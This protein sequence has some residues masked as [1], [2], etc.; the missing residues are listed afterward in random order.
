MGIAVIAAIGLFALGLMGYGPLDFDRKDRIRDYCQSMNSKVN[1][2]TVLMNENRPGVLTQLLD[3]DK[4]LEHVQK[5]LPIISRT[6]G[7]V[8][9]KKAPKECQQVKQAIL[10][11]LERFEKWAG[12]DIPRARDLMKNDRAAAKALLET[13]EKQLRTAEEGIRNEITVLQKKYF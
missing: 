8:E 6:K 3:S 9:S 10:V 2:L 5:S 11:A 4:S 7:E 12:E 13:A 1:L